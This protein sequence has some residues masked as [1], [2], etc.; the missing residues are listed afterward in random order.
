MDPSF[1]AY[2]SGELCVEG[3]PLAALAEG[4]ETPFF[5][6]SERQLRTAYAR[7]AQAF[8]AAGVAA[9]M[10]YCAK[11]NSEAAVLST[12]AACGASLLACHPAEVELARA[13]GFAA[14]RIAYQKPVL[15]PRELDSV[16]A[17]GV[18]LLH[19]HLPSDLELIAAAAARAGRRVSLSL[20]LAAPPALSPLR[21]LG[22]RTGL[23]ESEAL[24]VARAARGSRWLRVVG[25][26]LYLGTQQRTADS[27]AR[28]ARQAM[29]LLRR[30]AACGVEIE[31]VN[32][33][34][35]MP[36]PTLS[37]LTPAR[38]LPRLLDRRSEPPPAPPSGHLPEPPGQEVDPFAFR[39]AQRFAALTLP[40]PSRPRLVV[41]PGRSL[42]G[43]AGLLVAR[44]RAVRGRWL[45]LDASRDFLPESP[46]LLSRQVLTAIEPPSAARRF[47]HLSGCGSNTLDVI[48]LHRRLPAVVS[49]DLL[50]LCDAGAYSISRACHYTGL[51]PAVVLLGA[52]GS[53]R[54]ARRP[55]TVADLARPMTAMAPAASAAANRTAEVGWS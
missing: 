40:P 6:I 20:R 17:Q 7:M 29:R 15:T 24:A 52:D 37:R 21:A 54:L 1:L 51:P 4:R 12:L 2:R 32:L 42:I 35:G 47:V 8:S 44:V 30:L 10:R 48:D 36:S 38:L 34:G 46:W 23:S 26:N 55:E 45:F 49:G 27:L 25:V 11:T 50:V 5:L 31:E 33:G 16:L 19:V 13:C 39:L 43:A 28:A 22:R 53:P 14:E 41:E 3:V 18:G 9:E